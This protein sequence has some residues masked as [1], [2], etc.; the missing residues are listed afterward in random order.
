MAQNINKIAE[1]LFDKIRSRFEDVSLGDEDAKATTSPEQARFF[2]FNYTSQDGEEFGNVTVSIIDGTSIKVYFSTNISDKL[3]P[4]QQKEWYD[5][6]HSMRKFARRNLLSFDTRDI[7]RSNLN[8]KDIE[9][10]SKADTTVDA[11]DVKVTES[12]L[13][14]TPKT[15]F[16]NVGTARIRIIHTES[17]NPEIRGS[18][19]R[20][21]NAIY[22]ENAQG[23]RF[24]LEHNKLS[25]ARAMA[26]HISE[27]GNPYDSIGSHINTIIKEMNELG[28][29]VRSMRR[30][31]FEDAVASDMMEAAVSYYN[32]MHRQLNYLKGPRAYRTFV[33]NFEPQ[34][35]QLDEVDVNDIKERF[36]RRIFDDR[37]MPALPH[38]YK[39]YQLQEQYRKAQIDL[40]KNILEG[41][42]ALTLSINE[43][44]DEYMK[45]LRFQD[46]DTLVTRVLEDIAN[47]AVTMPEVADFASYWA[48]NYI[49]I[50]ESS[51]EQ[52]KENKTLAVQLATHY[53]KDL[54]QLKDSTDLRINFENYEYDLD[55]GVDL[56]DEGTW[57]VPKTPEDLQKLQQILAKPIPYGMDATNITSILYDVIG[58]DVL[59]DKLQGLVDDL[60]ENAD[61]VPA[62][63]RSEEHTSELQSH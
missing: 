7:S 19:A 15:S 27:G 42:T 45:M 21:I 33:E 50:N 5:F 39:A 11:K 23:E 56:L 29:F 6:L 32:G 53:L 61:A 57:A 62:V 36:V 58:D 43:G 22:V 14:G 31:T 20:H 4:Q 17:V 24:K 30:R 40:V 3:N 60:G 16:E 9:Q 47:R 10:V 38:V 25:G 63:K 26:R 34:A 37:M 2:N 8:I 46:A 49:N 41:N 13:Y 51:S 28:V 12:R 54:R 35:Q 55:P 48:K 52:L 18:R 59:F 44:M 1:N